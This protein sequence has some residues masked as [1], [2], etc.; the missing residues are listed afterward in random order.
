L[1]YSRIRAVRFEWKAARNDTSIVKS[2]DA[3]N[4]A[5]GGRFFSP[6]RFEICGS[7][8]RLYDVSRVYK[9]KYLD[10]DDHHQP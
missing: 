5:V 3:K 6:T 4:N 9:A 1:E 8:D 2:E 7:D 10:D